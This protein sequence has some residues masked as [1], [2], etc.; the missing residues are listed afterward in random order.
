MLFTVDL[1]KK[2]SKKASCNLYD[3]CECG[4]P[5][6]RLSD[7]IR[8]TVDLSLIDINLNRRYVVP[9]TSGDPTRPEGIV[10]KAVSV[11]ASG[12]KA[13]KYFMFGPE[14]LFPGERYT[15]VW[16]QQERRVHNNWFTLSVE[17]FLM[18]YTAARR[19]N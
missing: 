12:G 2:G 3:R 1:H 5:P 16:Q 10:K 8:N 19:P 11:L 14:Y 15:V 6:Q 9:R 18:R 13:L 17:W 7:A 4:L